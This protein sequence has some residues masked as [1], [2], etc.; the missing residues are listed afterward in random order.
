MFRMYY[1]SN[2]FL[3]NGNLICIFGIQLRKSVRRR[4]RRSFRYLVSF[5]NLSTAVLFKKVSGWIGAGSC[6]PGGVLDSLL[7]NGV[8]VESS[9]VHTTEGE[10]S[11]VK[12]EHEEPEDPNFYI[13]NFL[14]MDM[15]NNGKYLGIDDF[16]NQEDHK[17]KSAKGGH[18]S[19][20]SQ[21]GEEDLN[22]GALDGI[23]DEIDEVEGDDAAQSLAAACKDYLL[24]FTQEISA[25]NHR[26]SDK[27]RI[28]NSSS[29]SHSPR[30]SGSSNG[31]VVMSESSAGTDPERNGHDGTC[32]VTVN[33]EMK[34]DGR[35]QHGHAQQSGVINHLTTS[36]FGEPNEL[37]NMTTNPA[38][39]PYN[40]RNSFV[41]ASV[42]DMDLRQKRQRKPTRR[43]IEES[44]ETKLSRSVHTR[45][46]IVNTASKGQRPR[47]RP[48]GVL[49]NMMPGMMMSLPIEEESSEGVGIGT[50]SQASSQK[51]QA[52]KHENCSE[53]ELGE[54]SFEDESE[55]EIT[56]NRPKKGGDRR[57]HQ[58]MWTLPEVV[59]LVD[60][61]SE[62][63]VGRWTQIKRLSFAASPY[64]TPIDL[65]DKWRNLLRASCALKPNNA[66]TGPEKNSGRPLPKV[67]LRRVHELASLHP[68]PRRG[69]SKSSL[70]SVGKKGASGRNLRR[71]S[72]T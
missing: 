57:K 43:Y 1:Q 51:G 69:A 41:E 3:I 53:D 38:T 12:C 22:L 42:D 32:K 66:T 4:R 39:V 65:R 2:N 25:L 37:W 71:R 54:S 48:P 5:C 59:K 72:S 16:S 68:Y 8:K 9:L 7:M 11:Q 18:H 28:G 10:A 46:K 67:L 36:N 23:L 6:S 61:I 21:Q 14:S 52:E 44:T 49:R 35:D 31:A 55:D 26:P 45:E 20:I 62:F 56:R 60:G 13:D 27:I 30:C 29:D 63:G 50:S 47:G 19:Y 64:R 17:P 40:G 24:D 33:R 58:R 34:V 70:L 15:D